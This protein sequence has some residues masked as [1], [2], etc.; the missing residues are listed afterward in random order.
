MATD[1][2]CQTFVDFDIGFVKFI[3]TDIDVLIFFY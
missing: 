1:I 3:A 2:Q